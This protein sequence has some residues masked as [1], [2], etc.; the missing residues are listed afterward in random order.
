[1]E[2][3]TF[4]SRKFSNAYFHLLREAQEDAKR[5]RET[6]SF[7][8]VNQEKQR[9]R[10]LHYKKKGLIVL[11]LFNHEMNKFHFSFSFSRAYTLGLIGFFVLPFSVLLK[12][13]Q[14][15]SK[16]ML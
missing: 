15:N 1:M 13:K 6:T 14:L 9:V 3:S 5:A 7:A 16:C 10:Q 4:R 8:Q 2:K 12:K 11:K